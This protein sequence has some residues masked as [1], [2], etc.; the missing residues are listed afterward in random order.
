VDSNGKILAVD[1]GA[2]NIGLAYCDELGMTVQP[3]PSIPNI[4][5]KD[6]IQRIRTAIGTFDIRKLVIGIPLNM[7]GTRGDPAAR[8]ERLMKALQTALAIPVAGVDERLSSVDA[9]EIWRSMNAKQRKKYRT[10]DS[11]AA[12]L[13]LE[14][15]LKEK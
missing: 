2:R 6:F 8:M 7:D 15:Y 13:I 4:G 10:A 1:Y 14:R 11:L 12:A 5:R 3:L 9:E